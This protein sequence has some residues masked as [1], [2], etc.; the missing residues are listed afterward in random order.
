MP[1]TSLTLILSPY[2]VGL[3]ESPLHRSRVSSGPSHLLT[4]TS[5]LPTLHSLSLPI[6]TVTL[7]AVASTSEGEIGRSFELL[8]LTSAA[9]AAARGNAS[10]P[11]VLAGNCLASVGVFAGLT[12]DEENEIGCVWFDAHDD[13]NVP[14]TVVSGYFDSQ[15]IAMMAGES[16]RALMAT[17]PG[18]KP[19]DLRRVVH[20]GMR[21]VNELER[22]RV[23]G[24]E[25]GVVW[26][27]LKEEMAK[28]FRDEEG[29]KKGVLV[30]LDVDVLDVSVGKANAFACAGGLGE[31]DLR[32]CMRAIVE[33]ATPLAVTVASFDPFCDGEEKAKTPPGV[34]PDFL[35]PWVP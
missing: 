15:G 30:H 2:H 5:L 19:V 3:H 9:V 35:A 28:R 31:E 8:R 29:E 17:V 20:V 11:I 4:S 21:D 14:D 16:W 22:A 25:M 12:T 32:A 7:P 34:V 23:E 24:S 26:A 33:R 1:L 6:H 10:F 18:F 13:Y 27:G